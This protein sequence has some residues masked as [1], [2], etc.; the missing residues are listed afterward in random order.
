MLS[1]IFVASLLT[2]GLLATNVGNRVYNKPND[3]PVQELSRYSEYAAATYCNANTPA[4]EPVACEAN[5]DEV[6]KDAGTIIQS[7]NTGQ[8]PNSDIAGY[9]AVV[10]SRNEIIFAARG[11]ASNQNWETNLNFA[12]VNSLLVPGGKFHLGFYNAW[13]ELSPDVRAAIDKAQALHPDFRL[14][15]VGHSLGGAI[16]AVAAAHLRGDGYE[17]DLYTYGQPRVGNDIISDYISQSPGKL[18]RVT[19]EA[20]PVPRLPPWQLFGYRHTSPEIWLAGNPSD[21][22]NWPVEDIKICNGNLNFLCNTNP[23]IKYDPVDHGVYFGKMSCF[24]NATVD[25]VNTIPEGIS[26]FVDDERT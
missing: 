14:N 22:K 9:V 1:Q 10:P 3:V 8:A 19:H 13:I 6:L 5:C 23:F 4:G 7:F 26:K 12:L 25:A 16:A 24:K 20:D 21:P 2:S 18:Y 17:L 11:T 15:V